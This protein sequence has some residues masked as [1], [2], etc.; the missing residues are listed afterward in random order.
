M[1]SFTTQW[2]Y[3]RPDPPH[4]MSFAW[5]Q[6]PKG[7]TMK[8]LTTEED[9]WRGERNESYSGYTA[10]LLKQDL[11]EHKSL[12]DRLATLEA[13][14]EEMATALRNSYDATEWPADGT[15]SQEKALVT[16][17]AY[18]ATVVEKE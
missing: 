2:I 15:S 13:I 10:E 9:I 12:I 18:R 17:E 1:K 4:L 8:I 3:E 5:A 7:K 11:A 14:A 6:G 16:Y